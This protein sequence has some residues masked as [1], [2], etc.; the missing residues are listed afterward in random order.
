MISASD[1]L[2]PTSSPAAVL[3]VGAGA[4]GCAAGYALAADGGVVLTV[5]DDDRIEGSNLQR[6]ILYSDD[7]VGRPKA[8]T[9]AARLR[10]LFPGVDVRPLE[11]RLDADNARKL[12]ENHDYVID[13]TDDPPTKFLINRVAVETTTPF[14]YAGVAGTEGQLLAV[15]PGRSPC[16]ACLFPDET[17]ENDGGCAAHGI[18]APVAGVLGSLQAGA[19]RARLGQGCGPEPGRLLHYR[20]EGAGWR[21]VPLQRDPTCP[22]CGSPSIPTNA[23]RA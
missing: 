20:A 5:V 12:I 7:E 3:V 15:E 21:Q 10:S 23:R 8:A 13:A 11:T 2:Q 6:Q 14:C 22:R 18:L 4:L 17:S 16:L 19:A 9:A 1:S